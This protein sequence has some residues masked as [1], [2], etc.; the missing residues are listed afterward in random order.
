MNGSQGGF[1]AIPTHVMRNRE[2]SMTARG[3]FGVILSYAWGQ[4]P[5]LA[6][7]S[8][9]CNDCGIGK[10]ALYDALHQLRAAGLV[11]VETG[12]ASSGRRIWPVM[13]GGLFMTDLDDS[14]FRN[15]D[16]EVDEGEGK[17]SSK[18]KEGSP[19]KKEKDARERSMSERDALPVPGAQVL[20][21]RLAEL[22][23]GNDPKAKTGEHTKLWLEAADR[24]IR[25]DERHFE[26]ALAVLEWSQQDEFWKTNVLSMPTFRK[27]YPR[28]R[29]RWQVERQGAAAARTVSREKPAPASTAELLAAYGR[30]HTRAGI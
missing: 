14:G 23:K 17:E 22:M 1:V 30:P 26:E 6:S 25:I 27:Q 4:N 28:L 11:K 8:R 16:H 3:V 7:N 2:L 21:D 12:T 18:G 20:C 24:L 13:T 10:T 5:C 19:E 9:L 15:Q 29:M